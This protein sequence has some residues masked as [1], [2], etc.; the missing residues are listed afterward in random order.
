MTT[1]AKQKIFA[2]FQDGQLAEA[3]KLS[4]AQLERGQEDEELL[5]LLALSL[6]RQQKFQEALPVYAELARLFPS[7][8]LHVG[9]HGTALRDIGAL[10]E[11][12]EAYRAALRLD[13]MNIDQMLNLG[14]LQLQ[15]HRF[16]EARETL[17]DAF[18]LEP[19][20]PSIRIH[21]A[22]ACAACRDD[23]RVDDLLRPWRSWLP[24]EPEEQYELAILQLML[25]DANSV[26]A[27]L[28][29]LLMRMPSHLQAQLLLASVYERVNRLDLAEAKLQ[30]F[31]ADRGA[32]DDSV[33][34]EIAHQRAM[35][36]V[37]KGDLA[38]GRALLELSGPRT[39]DDYIHYFV[40]AG[41][42]DKLGDP[43]GALQA[44]ESAHELQTEEMRA[45][46]P[47]RFAPDAPIIPTA[48]GRVTVQD[49]RAW[50]KVSAPDASHSP[51]FI[52]GFPR[53]GTTLLE[54][55]LDAHPRLQ[56]M[57]ERPFF[58]VLVD[59][60]DNHEF[61]FPQDMHKLDQRDCDELRKAYVSMVCTKV[62]RRWDTQLVDK[63]P[64]NMLWLP[65][66]HRLFP[67]AKII[68]ALRHPCDVLLSNYMQNFR[69]TVLAM[70][71]ESLPKLARAYVV[72]MECWLDHVEVFK[73][74]VFVS[75]YE[76]LVADTVGQTRKIAEFI[77]L[78]DAS[79]MMNFDQHAR[80]KGYIATPSYAQV[81][82][83]VNRKGLGRWV[84]YRDALAPALPILQP[85]LDHWGYSV[86]TS[87]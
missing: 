45:V 63:N 81:I 6:Q 72:A 49:Y 33:R 84:R 73:P 26:Q 42:C 70:A 60:L 7:N 82:V 38:A 77:G 13:P 41:V 23:Q 56:S 85:M 74:N 2:A 10:V 22:R 12:E 47:D 29:D 5:F 25:G 43:R 78:E 34:L 50:P 39:P 51:V 19:Q 54:Q 17:L 35:L 53:S 79:A 46:V 75:R 36:A 71:C 86:D 44:L 59:R 31:E 67:E 76:E 48:V 11:A 87:V 61:Q 55:M 64:L 69:S 3:E 58:N 66:I 62:P 65:M 30:E 68:L 40:L 37:R 21:A 20:H 32:S 16:I 52:V 14:M 15:Q 18:A 8:S 27:L 1:P 83:P 80:D 4:R 57:D 28:E 24:L 9:N